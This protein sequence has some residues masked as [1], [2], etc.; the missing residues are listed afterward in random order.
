MLTLLFFSFH[1]MQNG[2][3]YGKYRMKDKHEFQELLIRSDSTILFKKGAYGYSYGSWLVG[4]DELILNSKKL[5]REDSLMIA[6]SRGSFFRVK[7]KK[8]SIKKNK[9]FDSE[10]RRFV[11]QEE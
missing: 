9:L 11:Y 10:G 3:K 1:P 8:F 7:N 2:L 6:L 5:N 4:D